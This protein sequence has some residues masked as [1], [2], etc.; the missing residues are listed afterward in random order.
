MG[1]GF[2]FGTLIQCP[3]A[4][5]GFIP[6]D[7]YDC[8]LIGAFFGKFFTAVDKAFR[9]SR[10]YDGK[11]S[12]TCPEAIFSS[13]SFHKPYGKGSE[14]FCISVTLTPGKRCIH[15]SH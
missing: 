10:R 2:L 8:S 7:A 13:E 3:Y 14:L 4:F 9:S 12:S 15:H 5:G 11:F 1:K 6:A